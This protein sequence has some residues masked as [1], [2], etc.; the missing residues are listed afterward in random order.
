M[1]KS[2]RKGASRGGGGYEQAEMKLSIPVKAGSA[3]RSSGILPRKGLGGLKM[4]NCF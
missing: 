3:L 2:A 1:A 4:G